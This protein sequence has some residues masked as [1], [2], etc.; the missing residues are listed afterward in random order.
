MYT[1]ADLNQQSV[2][3]LK[4]PETGIVNASR[5]VTSILTNKK[6]RSRNIVLVYDHE[7][8]L[9]TSLSKFSQSLGCKT[10]YAYC[11]L[12]T[13]DF[14]QLKYAVRELSSNLITNICV[15]GICIKQQLSEPDLLSLKRIAVAMRARLIIANGLKRE[16]FDEET[17]SIARAL[18]ASAFPVGGNYIP[19]I[20]E[21][22]VDRAKESVF[23]DTSAYSLYL[24]DLTTNFIARARNTVGRLD[25]I[26]T[27]N[28]IL[29]IIG[30]NPQYV[31]ST[32]RCGMRPCF[33]EKSIEPSMLS[34]ILPELPLKSDM[35]SKAMKR[36]MYIR[37]NGQAKL[38]DI[39]YTA[40][41][42][43]DQVIYIG[44]HP[45]QH[46]NGFDLSNHNLVFIDPNF[47]DE[48]MHNLQKL[49]KNIMLIKGY[50]DFSIEGLKSCCQDVIDLSRPFLILDDSWIPG[51]VEYQTMQMEKL[52][53]F[54]ELIDGKFECTVVMKWNYDSDIIIKHVY[55][56]LPQPNAGDLNEMRLVLSKYGKNYTYKVSTVRKYLDKFKM[57]NFDVR[58][59]T[60]ANYHRLITTYQDALQ[61]EGIKKKGAA[62]SAMFSIT[63]SSNDKSKTLAWFKEVSRAGAF[64]ILT[65]PNI[66]RLNVTKIARYSIGLEVSIKNGTFVFSS[67]HTREP[68][69]DNYF[70]EYEMAEASMTRVTPEM[71]NGFMSIKY[72]GVGY[73]TNS[74][75]CDLF[76]VYIPTWLSKALFNY[77]NIGTSPMGVIKSVTNILISSGVVLRSEYYQ[78]RG[79]LLRNYLI[80][81]GVSSDKMAVSGTE[82]QS[83]FTLAPISVQTEFGLVEL[84]SN[85]SLNI[86]GHLLSMV[87]A[88]HFVPTAVSV[89]IAQM[90]LITTK[91]KAN[92]VHAYKLSKLQFFDNDI[93][94]D[95]Y[96]KVWHTMNELKLT[97]CIM[98]QYVEMIL[99]DCYQ[100]QIVKDACDCFKNLL[101]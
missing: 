18:P 48:S 3:K 15:L 22:V 88:S 93:D 21:Q 23:M 84:K 32:L 29:N 51:R 34:L 77:Q 58:S 73:F 54:T 89:W 97:F 79:E 53:F 20:Y 39:D 86:S 10:A 91:V 42:M 63:N 31:A 43:C 81:K 49:N 46:L 56:L 83:L 85:T 60:I 9:K 14:T 66:Y 8:N 94:K 17:K 80:S 41:A 40:L 71:M 27:S 30:Y 64:L 67:P 70:T 33:I 2:N 44:A 65:V 47:T 13:E 11:D 62:I 69:K 52:R 28:N 82:Y 38:A 101:T 36:D 61:V 12:E 37:S 16:V 96:F 72:N 55:A 68:W 75:Y 74:D 57:L 26:P 90:A 5:A 7:M 92:T 1:L 50:F 100:P 24:R 59:R 98:E 25:S 78:R 99:K 4:I 6:W 95:G 45:A 19:K 87:V 35:A 76:D